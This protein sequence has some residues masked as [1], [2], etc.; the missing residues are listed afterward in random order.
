MSA[1]DLLAA[2]MSEDQLLRA[3]LEHATWLGLLTHHCRPA[4]TA[5]GWR[6]PIQGTRGF[7]DLAIAGPGGLLLPETKSA[8]GSLDADQRRWRDV[9]LASGQRWRLWKPQ[10]WLSGEI[11]E[12]LQALAKETNHG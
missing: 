3:V 7:P 5:T 8:S 2:H 9:L 11:Q 1:R 10:Q 6:T 4:R 12:E